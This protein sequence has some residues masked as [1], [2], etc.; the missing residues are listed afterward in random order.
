[1]RGAYPDVTPWDVKY[2]PEASIDCNFPDGC[3]TGKDWYN[4]E[5]Y[6]RYAACPKYLKDNFQ[7]ALTVLCE[8]VPGPK[9]ACVVEFPPGL[10][11]GAP[12]LDRIAQPSA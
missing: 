11:I 12:M 9:V 4:R 5:C 3:P 6:M 8:D 7:V 2:T 10:M 1:L